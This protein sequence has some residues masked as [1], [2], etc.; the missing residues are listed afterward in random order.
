MPWGEGILDFGI[1]LKYP[2]QFSKIRIFPLVGADYAITVLGVVNN[3][4]RLQF[5][6]GT[7][8][9]L[10]KAAFLRVE[11]LYGFNIDGAGKGHTGKGSELIH[12]SYQN[13]F[14][15]SINIG[16]GGRL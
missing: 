7:D 16:I 3:A 1:L 10:N 6:F 8:F 15:P 2:F 14:G 13:T 4:L 12:Y 11:A 9:L 5:G